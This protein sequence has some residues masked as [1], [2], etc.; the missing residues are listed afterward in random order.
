MKRTSQSQSIIVSGESGAGKTEST[1]Y[2]LRYLCETCSGPQAGG[3]IQIEQL[4]LDANPLLEAFGNAKT[5][6]NNNSSRFG[7]FIEVYLDSRYMVAGGHISHYLLE[8]SRICGQIS[9]LERNYHIFY[10]LCVGL[11]EAGWMELKLGPPEKFNYLRNGCTRYFLHKQQVATLHR[12]RIVQLDGIEDPIVN[13]LEDFQSM[14][15]ALGHFGQSERQK[16]AIYRIVAAILHLG[17]ISFEESTDDCKGGCRIKQ[18]HESA[19]ALE[20]AASLLGVDREQLQMGLLSRV[21][22][23]NKGGHKGSI[24]MVPLKV[25]EAQNARDA[26]AKAIYSRLFDYIVS[27]IINQ[28]LPLNQVNGLKRCESSQSIGVLDI[29]GF[30]YFQTNSFEQ[31]CINYCNEKL[32]N[33]FNERILNAE[34]DLYEVEGLGI[35]RIDYMNNS[36]CIE[37]FEARSKG[38]FH[39]L[40][41]E[42]RLP[43][44]SPQHFTASVHTTH[45]GK[46]RIGIPRKSKLKSHREL[47][48]DEGF[49][50]RHFAGAVCYQTKMFIEKN[51][52]TLHTNLEFLMLESSS[53]LMKCLFQP[54]V[55][56]SPAKSMVIAST[57]GGGDKSVRLSAESV[58]GKFRKQLTKLIEKLDSTGTHFVRCIKPNF[59]MISKCFEGG[60]ILSQLKCSGMTTVLRVMQH[61]YPSRATYAQIYHL[62][63]PHLPPKLAGYEPRFFCK[64]LVNSVGLSELTDV[65]LGVTKVFFRPG[66]FAEFDL[67]LKNDDPEA[68]D[69]LVGK[70]QQWLVASR[71][72]R[73]QWGVYSVIKRKWPPFHPYLTSLTFDLFSEEHH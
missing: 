12:K 39:L 1:K 8:K 54:E 23:T 17:N 33:F 40:D 70:V 51:N 58:G 37:L 57:G 10:Q 52:D 46:F 3:A 72:K 73:A 35:K 50:I 31:F 14:D 71:W 60:G 69:R 56:S 44:P 19:E 9:E 65:R 48:D 36:D 53:P 29:A 18:N 55:K 13:D 41:E 20:N 15:Q 7:K 43:R 5:A 49:L 32:Q 42:S 61:G 30:E 47:R 24:Y 68:L 16:R 21:M 6:R 45:G 63:S 28:A 22:Q 34:Q 67:L 4:I 64:A 66:R 11:P 59:S 62:Y 38:I 25:H 2:V 27:V 26:L